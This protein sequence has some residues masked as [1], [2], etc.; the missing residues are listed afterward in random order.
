M[1]KQSIVMVCVCVGGRVLVQ[2][3]ISQA[4]NTFGGITV[5]KIVIWGGKPSI[6]WMKILLY[7]DAPMEP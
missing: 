7:G 6:L 3:H 1:L 4:K 5:L 2:F